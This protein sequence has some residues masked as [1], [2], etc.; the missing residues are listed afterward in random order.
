MVASENMSLA[1]AVKHWRLVH[2]YSLSEG[3]KVSGIPFATLRR[4]EH[5]SEPRKETLAKV[6]NILL[7][8]TDEV[9][10]KYVLGID[11]N[12]KDL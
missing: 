8:T 12:K 6:A 4:I 2:G 10:S 1:D 9:Y 5:G 3:A 7:M 11:S